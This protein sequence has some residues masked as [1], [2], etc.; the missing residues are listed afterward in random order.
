MI[1][2]MVELKGGEESG[3]DL[4]NFPIRRLL[5]AHVIAALQRVTG[6]R[7]IWALADQALVS[8]TNFLTNVIVARS[9]GLTEFGVFALAWMAVLFFG[10]MQMASII[11]PMMSLG[12]K[13]AMEDRPR[14]F[15][16]VIVQ[17]FVFAGVSTLIL[18]FGLHLIALLI[19]QPALDKLTFPL[20]VTLLAYLLQDFIRRYLF[21]TKQSFRAFLN[22]AVSC[23]PQL[24]LI[25]LF[26]HMRH[27]NAPGILW[28]IAL[29]SLMGVALGACWFERVTFSKAAI[30]ST[31]VR[32]W[33][34]SRWLAPSA[35]LWWTSTNFF[36][37]LAPV[38][39][40]AIASGVLRASQNIVGVAHIWFLG[41]DNVM[42]VETARLLHEEGIASSSRY[43]RHMS[44]RW[45]GI[46]AIFVTVLSAAPNFWLH[47]IYGPKY[48]A[49]GYLLR[50]YGIS[51][52]LVFTGGPLKAG[53]QALEYTAPIFW[54]YLA[55]TALSIAI[56]SP[57][58][59]QLGLQGVIIGTI[60]IQIIFQSI[61][62]IALIRRSR[63]IGQN[64]LSVAASPLKPRQGAVAK[65]QNNHSGEGDA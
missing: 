51:Y 29:T 32:H 9:L 31:M 28:L 12:P 30:K 13:T 61:L 3:V 10:S 64:P 21:T 2:R 48:A 50:L 53:L 33:G 8:G 37:L 35:L 34:I 17:E 40:G 46:T 6:G 57:L 49:Y 65:S 19:H 11:A 26:A 25:F 45:G 59:K 41:L 16:A 27:I 60:T 63:I 42:P 24:P 54:S 56:A 58:T 15:G 55:M 43:L 38:Y 5:T 22:D 14:Y 1:V 7:E 20:C 23:L 39:Y 47:L 18:F 4:T 36:V 62:L 44:I 52:V